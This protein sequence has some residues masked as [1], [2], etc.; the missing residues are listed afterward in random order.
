MVGTNA[1][2]GRT[3]V[4]KKSQMRNYIVTMP[5]VFEQ[6]IFVRATSK[7]DAIEQCADTG[8]GT[9]MGSPAFSHSLDRKRWSAKRAR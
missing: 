7:K 8:A 5:A 4:K 3:T 2:K 6:R 9:F 1:R